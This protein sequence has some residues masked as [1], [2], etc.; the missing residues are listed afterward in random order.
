[1]DLGLGFYQDIKEVIVF[2]EDQSLKVQFS[3]C[4]Y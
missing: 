2:R 4:E 3:F 1:M